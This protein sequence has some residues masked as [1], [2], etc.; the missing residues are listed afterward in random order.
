MRTALAIVS[1]ILA[2][3]LGNRSVLAEKGDEWRWLLSLHMF[4]SRTGWAVSAEGG[5]G[6]FS[7][8]AV[9]SVVRTSDGGLHWR[10]V[11]PIAPRG[12]DLGPQGIGEVHALSRFGA[13]V[14]AGLKQLRPDGRQSVSPV[15]FHTVDGGQTWTNVTTSSFGSMHFM[16][17][18]D[19]WMVLGNDVHRSTDGGK[20]WIKIG[21]AEF[22]CRTRSTTQSIAFLNA[23][24]GWITGYCEQWESLYHFVTRDGGYTW[25]E[26]KLPQPPQMTYAAG[27]NVVYLPLPPAISAGVYPHHRLRFFTAQDGILPVVYS[28]LDPPSH[29]VIASFVVFYVTH[30]AGITWNYSTPVR[31]PDPDYCCLGLSFA[32]ANHGWVAKERV[33]YMTSDGARRWTKIQPG[34]PFNRPLG[35]EVNF[36]SPQVGW[37]TGQ[38]M[39][40]PFL[41]K[42]LDGGRSWSPV[43]YTILR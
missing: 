24:T 14:P 33:L 25:Q 7:R 34:L 3:N 36:I 40:K 43:P 13:W 39:T 18:R 28:N 37:A 21:S 16:N 42:T 6:A 27:L 4:D 9:G 38:L 12:Q 5:G 29:A 31:L 30:D 1:F 11:T 26:Q 17:P 19:G 41:L 15:L 20:T 23:T 22:H 2:L 8:G 10:D 35:E 32:D